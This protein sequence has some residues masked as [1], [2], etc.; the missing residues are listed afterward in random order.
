MARKKKSDIE[1][2][3]DDFINEEEIDISSTNNTYLS[4]GS[5][6]L[7][8]ILSGKAKGGLIP[9]IIVNPAGGSHSGKTLLAKTI[10]AEA[11]NNPAFDDYELWMQDGERG[12]LFNDIE[13]FGSKLAN[14]INKIVDNSM[15]RFFA[16]ITEMTDAGKKFIYVLDSFDSLM[17]F[18]DR[19]QKTDIQKAVREGK[20]I[21]TQDYPRR[22]K[23]GHALSRNIAA[24]I[25]DTGSIIINISQERE[26]MGATMF[27]NKR[28]RSGG[29]ALEYYSHLIFWLKSGSVDKE[30]EG[31]ITFKK[32][33]WVTFDVT[34][35]RIS[36][37][38]GSAQLYVLDK[39]GIDDIT[40]NIEFLDS[41][42][43]LPMEKRSYVIDE[44]GFKGVKDSLISFIEENNKEDELAQMVENAWNELIESK[45]K[46]RK[47]KYE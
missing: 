43:K 32:G 11:A 17:C 30:K 47:K 1:T 40:S 7:N 41:L 35:N 16:N 42:N 39:H 19:K 23:F 46:P 2:E 45:T 12:D 38:N 6:L 44:W 20:E 29:S 9:G 31:T 25:A 37:R 26:K 15:E 22:A 10:L 24:A 8:L 13:Y 4:T 5:T 27:E 14:R 34:K 18:D 21:N 28:T 36:G 3:L 33:N